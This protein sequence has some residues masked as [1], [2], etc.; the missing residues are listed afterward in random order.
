MSTITAPTRT[1]TEQSHRVNHGFYTSITYVIINIVT[2][3]CFLGLGIALIIYLNDDYYGVMVAT[4]L[5]LG[6]VLAFLANL[7]LAVL[8]EISRKLSK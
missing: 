8:T 6:S 3:L 4:P 2:F 7:L 1:Y 5:A